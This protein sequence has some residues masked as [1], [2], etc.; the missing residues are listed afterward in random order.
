MLTK[1][2]K[3]LM[4]LADDYAY[5]ASLNNEYDNRTSKQAARDALE[6]ALMDMA[7]EKGCVVE[8]ERNMK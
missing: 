8:S 2:I 7:R 4:V 6:K 5:E 1:D 3:K